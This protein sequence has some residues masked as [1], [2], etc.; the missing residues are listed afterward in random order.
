MV[1]QSGGYQIRLENS[2]SAQENISKNVGHIQN[3]LDK[4]QANVNFQFTYDP[5]FKKFVRELRDS[6]NKDYIIDKNFL[7]LKHLKEF[8]KKIEGEQ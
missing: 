2:N 5:I 6:E 3:Q 1:G 4:K 7:V 8:Y